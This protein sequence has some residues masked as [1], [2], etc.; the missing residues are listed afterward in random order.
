MGET[1]PKWL[2]KIF[3]GIRW[4]PES[5]LNTSALVVRLGEGLA[6]DLESAT[7]PGHALLRVVK[8]TSG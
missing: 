4:L 5:V 3:T 8:L 1:N 2:C 6:E 7:P